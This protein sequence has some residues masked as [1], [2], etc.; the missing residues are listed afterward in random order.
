MVHHYEPYSLHDS[1]RV[2]RYSYSYYAYD[3]ANDTWGNFNIVEPAIH[4]VIEAIHADLKPHFTTVASF[5][6]HHRTTITI[7]FVE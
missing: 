3:G 2:R 7:S 4:D 1:L 5:L 6:C